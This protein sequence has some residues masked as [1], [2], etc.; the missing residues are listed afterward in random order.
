MI[1]LK[2]KVGIVTGGAGGLGRETART[3]SDLGADLIVTDVSSDVES[4]VEGIPTEENRVVHHVA[5]ITDPNDV[6]GVV[7]RAL[8][9][10]DKI[11][12]LLNIAGVIPR[13]PLSE[14]KLEEWRDTIEV[15]LNGTFNMTQ[16]VINP[17]ENNRYGRI[18]NVSSV[19][20]GCLGMAG[21]LA[22]YSASKAGVVGFTKSAAIDLG[23]K[24]I[25]VNAIL[26]GMIDTEAAA[27][28]E[29]A[30]KEAIDKTPLGRKAAPGEIAN[31]MAFLSSQQSS[32]VTGT[33][34]IADGGQIQHQMR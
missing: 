4:V 29:D 14:I 19:A 26:P 24:G 3:F 8:N 9:E 21:D 15:N 25:T 6:N 23:P 33:T 5:D 2:G 34:I 17:M 22:H 7:Q 31:V 30:E 12:I 32:Y 18:V 28:P 11:D 13:T 10:F 16:R 27:S 1:D 20:G